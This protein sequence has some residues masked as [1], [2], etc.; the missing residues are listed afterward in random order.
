MGDYPANWEADVVL[1][2]GATVHLRPIQPTD[3]DGL[4]DF[5]A[6]LSEQTVY[7]RF[8][9]PYPVL[10]DRDIDRFTHVN[11]V[12]RAALVATLHDE[13]V[14]VVRYE[15][16]DTPT[17]EVAFVI[18]D[19]HHGRGLGSVF[20]E[21][22]AAAAWDNG[23][24][25]FVA[26][27][28]PVNSAMISTF[29]QAGYEP[30]TEL[31]DGVLRLELE[32]T[33]TEAVRSVM[34][35]REHRAEA[36][37]VERLLRPESIAVVGASR[38]PRAAGHILLR[39]LSASGFPGSLYA[40]NP[41]ASGEIHGVPAYASVKDIPDPVHLAVVAVPAAAVLDVAA[42]CG[43]RGDVRG[44]VVVSAGFAETGPEG[45]Q[46]QIDL[47]TQARADGMRVIGP[48]CLGVINTAAEAS[49]NASMSPVMPGRGRIGF[50]SQ[51]GALGIAL[52]ETLMSRGLGLSSFVSAGNRADVSGNDLMQYWEEDVATDVLL[53]Y[54]ES[55]GNPR[56]FSRI[57]RR[58]S[59][60]K[61]IVAVKSGR[62]TQGIPLGHRVRASALPAAAVDQMFRQS[63]VIQVETLSE[64]F[65][66]AQVLTF[67]PLPCGRRVAVLGNSDALGVLAADACATWGLEL[68]GDPIYFPPGA[69]TDA[70]ACTL[71][72]VIDDPAVDSVV[73]MFIPRVGS[74]GESIART[75]GA[76]V[77]R[78][79]K[80]V[81]ATL[82]AVE[83]TSPFLRK[84]SPDGVPVIGSVPTFGSVEDAV[85]ALARATEYA[86]WRDRPRGSVPELP[87]VDPAAARI[88]VEEAL[89]AAE[90][91]DES[92]PE[93]SVTHD[94]EAVA[95]VLAAYGI[96]VWPTLP[97]STPG[98]AVDSAELLGYPVVLKAVSAPLRLRSDLGAVRF[99]LRTP[100][101]VHAAWAAMVATFG[102]GVVDDLVVQ[103]MAG[104][105]VSCE[106]ASVEDALFG[107]V[108]SF[109][110]G[111][112][113]S[114][115][116]GDRG[117]RIPPLTDVDAAELVKAP[118]ASP[119]LFGYRGTGTLDVGALEDLLLRVSRLSDDLPEM[120]R[121]FL[122]PIVVSHRGAVVLSASARVALPLARTDAGGRR[123]T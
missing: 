34:A 65:D 109:G 76:V 57:A 85:R 60:T 119:L 87:D 11:H 68:V 74:T 49:F 66:V 19:D 37:S 26:D 115:L 13:I 96:D 7:F 40:V 118:K 100:D 71:A 2:D 108:V 38:D 52:L 89:L 82:L 9:A 28:L 106:I 69:A 91:A 4:V 104:P 39:H 122:N 79:S 84:L 61:P 21:H 112:V 94:P 14:G 80:P 72:A 16:I 8:F 53:L 12:D 70:Y 50:F 73:T 83:G 18:R 25:R 51:S 48:N 62:S 15:R 20:L 114:E 47:V 1:R 97:G 103:R 46:R 6:H 55:I 77:G 3:G 45:Q 111:G 56:K 64:M 92:A 27:V 95:A 110:L 35:A 86:L 59:L 98:K 23:I 32:I 101:A 54:L 81:V 113:T 90:P 17:A 102:D 58:T 31:E 33:P 43:A 117:Y 116:V 41:A 93:G 67:Q 30:R 78:T 63:G 44:L 24:R 75:L 120:A 107:P 22:I 29:R 10:S 123:L 5:H 121:L 99:D 88:V 36:R 42:E 105:G